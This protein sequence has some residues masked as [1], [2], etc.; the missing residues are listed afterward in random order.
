MYFSIGKPWHRSFMDTKAQLHFTGICIEIPGS[1][2]RGHRKWYLERRAAAG[3]MQ[4]ATEGNRNLVSLE[5]SWKQCRQSLAQ[6]YPPAPAKPG[7]EAAPQD[8]IRVLP[9]YV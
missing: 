7:F 4:I 9:M 1:T 6:S 2:R 5:S 3:V 8:A